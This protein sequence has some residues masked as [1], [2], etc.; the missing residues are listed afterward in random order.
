MAIAQS[1]ALQINE[2]PV[3]DLG[4]LDQGPAAER[5]LFD[6]MREACETVGFFYVENHGI[7]AAAADSI[8]AESRRFFALPM[9]ERE[10]L[11]LTRS[12][13][14][15]GYLAIG[16]RGANLDRPPDLLEAFNLGQDLGPD[17]PGVK[18]GKALHCP[19]Q[20]PPSLPDFR[21]AVGAYQDTMIRLAHGCCARSRARST[22]RSRRWRRSSPSRSPRSGCCIIRRSLR[23]STT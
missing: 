11:L 5:R 23:P 6:A 16:A 17:H 21:D 2:I 18:A 12:P 22:F 10:A 13:F 3:L 9:A 14:Y 15:R 8:F 20:W 1:R 7:A 4:L 19:N